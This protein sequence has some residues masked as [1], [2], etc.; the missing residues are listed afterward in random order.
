MNDPNAGF[1]I[2]GFE[3]TNTKVQSNDPDPGA[4]GD[5]TSPASDNDSSSGRGCFIATAA[6][7]SY[8]EPEV[9]VLRRFRDQWLQTN[10]LGQKLVEAYYHYSPP[11][12]ED[13][14]KSEGLRFVTRVGLTPLVYALKALEFMNNSVTK[15]LANVRA[16][17]EEE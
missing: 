1:Y 2:E 14:A 3:F 8:L 4:G 15:A 16:L 12:A 9:M 17:W 13:L 7:G 5:T 11:I 10:W 6:Y